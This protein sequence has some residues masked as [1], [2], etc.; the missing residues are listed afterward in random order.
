M[1][2]F[3]ISLIIPTYKRESQ[4]HKIISSIHNQIKNNVRIEILVCDSNSQYNK[5]KLNIKKKN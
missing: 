1:S 5:K 3:N 2:L 4:V